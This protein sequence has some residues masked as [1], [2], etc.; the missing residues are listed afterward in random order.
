MKEKIFESIK[1]SQIHITTN[2]DLSNHDYAKNGFAKNGVQQWRL[3][4][5]SSIYYKNSEKQK[6]QYRIGHKEEKRIYDKNYHVQHADEYR[7]KTRKWTRVNSERKKETDKEYYL[8]NKETIAKQRK[9]YRKAN[10]KQIS[11]EKKKYYKANKETI[12][13]KQKIYSKIKRGKGI[14]SKVEA[15][16]R[17]NF[18][19][20]LIGTFRDYK[21][22]SSIDFHHIDNENVIEIPRW[23]HRKYN[24]SKANTH[25]ENI[26]LAMRDFLNLE[27]Y[28]IIDSKI[29]N[30]YANR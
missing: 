15:R 6:E 9:V 3:K 18:G 24:N 13:V 4:S 23:L 14:K 1:K 21:I 19:F 12:S 5:A 2:I 8:K 10:F 29:F 11:E 16:R 20:H 26:R 30:E 27:Y 17:R 7:E 22:L 28:N 25:R